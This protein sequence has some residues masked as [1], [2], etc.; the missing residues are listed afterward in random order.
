MILEQTVV[1]LCTR[2]LF[3]RVVATNVPPMFRQCFSSVFGMFWQFSTNVPSIFQQ[4]STNVP[5][6]FWQC[7]GNF[8]PMFLQRPTNIP[9]MFW[10]LSTSLPVRFQQQS[11]ST[12]VFN[13]GYEV[14]IWFSPFRPDRSMLVSPVQ[15]LLFLKSAVCSHAGL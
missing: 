1:V 10:Q 2:F 9:P 7:C 3:W 5:A 8:P 14:W 6:M 12:P 4:R 15:T 11:G 13:C